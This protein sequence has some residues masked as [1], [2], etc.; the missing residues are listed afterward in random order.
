MIC[1]ANFKVVVDY[2]YSSASQIFPSILGELG[3]E[4]IA[5]NAHI[6]ETKITKTKVMLT[7]ASQLSQIVKLPQ[8]RP[9]RHARHGRGKDL[10]LRRERAILQGDVEL[11]VWRS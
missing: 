9:G 6:D 4:V 8:R 5:L 11:A 3:I 7:R 2:A 10:P 1:A